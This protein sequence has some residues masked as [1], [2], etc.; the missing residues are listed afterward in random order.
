[1]GDSILWKR[2]IQ[3]VLYHE[4]G[5]TLSIVPEEVLDIHKYDVQQLGID[6]IISTLP[7]DER[8]IPIFQISVVPTQRE[9]DDIQAFLHEK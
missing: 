1:M 6:G 3:G 2:Y 8:N 9:L 4:F 5:T 7:L